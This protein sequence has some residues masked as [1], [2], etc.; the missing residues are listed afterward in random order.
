MSEAPS[1][2]AWAFAPRFRRGAF[3]WR[4]DPAIARIREALSEIK[5]I[6][7]KE[8]IPAAEGAV[9]FLSRLSPSLQSI[10]D[11]RPRGSVT[12]MA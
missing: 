5:A 10:D 4:S 6:N 11:P 2:H 3:G 1:K 12:V 9:L 7:R 8:P